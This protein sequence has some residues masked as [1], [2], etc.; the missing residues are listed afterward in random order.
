VDEFFK[1]IRKEHRLRN[2]EAEAVH[3]TNR[4]NTIIRTKVVT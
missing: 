2:F 1:E 3:N 4:T